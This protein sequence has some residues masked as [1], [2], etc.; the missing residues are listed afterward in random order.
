MCVCAQSKTKASK[1]WPCRP[2]GG[3]AEE[4]RAEMFLCDLGRREMT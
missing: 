4:V 2:V 3:G 1:T